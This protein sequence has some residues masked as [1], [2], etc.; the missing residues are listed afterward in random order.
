MNNFIAVVWL[1]AASCCVLV[2]DGMKANKEMAEKCKEAEMDPFYYEGGS[3]VTCEMR[4]LKGECE[5]DFMI[6]SM[7]CHITC[8]FC[9]DELVGGVDQGLIARS[10]DIFQ[11]G[12]D[13]QQAQVK[14]TT[15]RGCKCPTWIY[16]G[17]T[18]TGCANPNRSIMGAWCPVDV[19]DCAADPHMTLNEEISIVYEFGD[20]SSEVIPIKGEYN[21]D[22]C[23]C[24]PEDLC[25]ISK[26]GC[27]CAS[28]CSIPDNDQN[29]PWCIIKP[30][31]C[32]QDYT[33]YRFLDPTGNSDYCKPGCCPQ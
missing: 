14:T 4:K 10:F 20:G 25:Q 24:F 6:N 17:T 30:G 19:E 7:F 29:G 18:Y 3:E 27:E 23:D 28:P 9:P 15:L 11:S 1:L 5:Q 16:N 32:K 21:I 8:G 13:Q 2:V 22:G 26:G 12:A 33:P 31:S